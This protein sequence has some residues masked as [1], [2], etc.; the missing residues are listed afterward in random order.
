MKEK[1]VIKKHK[2]IKLIFIII[3]MFIIPIY[4]FL[5]G[6]HG[7][8]ILMTFSQVG[9]RID[10]KL[11]GLIIWGLICA[12][13]FYFIIEYMQ[14]MVKMKNYF[15]TGSLLLGCVSLILTVFLPFNTV[16]YPA[17]IEIHNNLARVAVAMIIISVL[18]FVISLRRFD[19]KV[20]LK[21]IIAFALSILILII[22]FLNCGVS[23]IFQI[24]FASIMAYLS[25]LIFLFIEKSK[26]LDL[27]EAILS[28]SEA[29]EK[30]KPSKAFNEE[31][32]SVF[33]KE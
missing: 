23:S 9:G 19:E 10:G 33:D 13:Y 8:L 12:I 3:G 2:R 21:S 31:V 25:I 18:L 22:C 1:E 5:F 14:M 26:K 27:Q 32:E 30:V 6:N 28:K 7:D 24:V 20:F 11:E 16:M 29:I 17:S 4:S 15:V